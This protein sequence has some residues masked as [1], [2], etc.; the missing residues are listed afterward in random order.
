M[1]TVP[2]TTKQYRSNLPSGQVGRFMLL[3][4]IGTIDVRMV[5]DICGTS[6]AK[7]PLRLRS[8]PP[9]EPDLPIAA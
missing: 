6:V 3:D 8:Q 9:T 2:T 1:L 5:W 4:R 7:R